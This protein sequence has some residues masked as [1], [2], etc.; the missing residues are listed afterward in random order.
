MRGRGNEE[1]REREKKKREQK[2]NTLKDIFFNLLLVMWQSNKPVQTSAT[3][4]LKNLMIY[5]SE[6]QKILALQKN[7]NE[8]S[9][10]YNRWMKKIRRRKKLSC[11]L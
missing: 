5:H 1:E 4:P 7:L 3:S 9:T 2:I 8:A 11:K 6:K 10:S